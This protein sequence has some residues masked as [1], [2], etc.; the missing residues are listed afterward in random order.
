MGVSAMVAKE[1]FAPHERVRQQVCLHSNI[2]TI[3]DGDSL[4]WE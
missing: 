2:E 1:L 4:L 3:R